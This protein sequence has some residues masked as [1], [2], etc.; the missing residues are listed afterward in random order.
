M[1]AIKKDPTTRQF[2][3]IKKRISVASL[4]LLSS[5]TALSDPTANSLDLD[6]AILHYTENDNRVKATALM[7]HGK[8]EIGDDEYLNTKFEIDSLTG[9]TPSG[10]IPSSQT[11]TFTRPSGNGSI[12]TAPGEVPINDTF[13]DTRI[14]TNIS[15]DRPLNDSLKTNVG[16]HLSSEAGY[17]SISANGSLSRSFNMRTTTI[18]AGLAIEAGDV[19]P[20]GGIPTELSPVIW[21]EGEAHPKR[22]PSENR[23]QVDLIIGLNQII[24]PYTVMR[25]NFSFSEQDGYLNMFKYVS[26]VD[27][28]TGPSQGDPLFTIFENRPNSRSKRNF[29][30]Q[31]MHSFKIN[32]LD[33]SYRYM[34]DNWDIKSHTIDLH[35]NWMQ[36][37]GSSWQPHVRYYE[38]TAAKFYRTLLPVSDGIPQHVSAD[39]RLGDMYSITLGLKYS[40]ALAND[41]KLELRIELI[42]QKNDPSPDSQ[43]GTQK[44]HKLVLDTPDFDTFFTK[45]LILLESK[46]KLGTTLKVSVDYLIR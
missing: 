42:S 28:N 46:N 44:N 16:L 5:T 33:L 7:L 17:E 12:I 25:F 11:Q 9:S 15:W 35:Y 30:W 40:Y 3:D 29:F 4:T 19:N 38:Q 1:V 6:V 22:A 32:S 10:A 39:Y 2:N 36:T 8:K 31:T 20:G 34:A 26:I 41:N 27:D 18:S 13:K 43:I 23:D 24:S 21:P 37:G 45:P 14:A